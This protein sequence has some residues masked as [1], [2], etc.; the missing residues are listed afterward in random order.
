MNDMT[1]MDQTAAGDNLR[2]NSAGRRQHRRPSMRDLIFGRSGR[3]S[4]GSSSRSRTPG[5]RNFKDIVPKGFSQAQQMQYTPEQMK[6]FQQMFGSSSP[7]SY[8]SRLAGGDESDFEEMEAPAWRQFQEAQG[9]LGSRY[10]QLA[11]GAMSAKNGS[12]FRNAANQQSSNF[13]MNLASRRREL[14]RQAI[15]DLQ[16]IGTNLLQ[17]R[18][19]DRSLVENAP[20]KQ[21]QALGGWGG[22]AGA[23]GGGLLG[24]VIPGIGTMAG[25]TLGSSAFGGM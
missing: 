1:M 6:L 18:P 9:Q 16:G 25:A 22:V 11:P 13:A 12:G 17:Q 10:A 24:S 2:G 5:I 8:L 4:L 7:D 15:M 23:V 14:Q 19:M 21:K 3:S 20:K